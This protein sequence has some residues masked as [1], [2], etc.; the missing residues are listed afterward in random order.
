VL[1]DALRA[2]LEA[3]RFEEPTC[4]VHGDFG[5]RNLII[6]PSL[7]RIAGVIDWEAA[8]T[9]SPL[10]D[11]GSLFRHAKR[12][13]AAFRATFERAHGGLPDDWYRRARVLDAARMVATLAE[14]RP[15]RVSPAEIRA[16]IEEIV[17]STAR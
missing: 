11:I 8:A 5:R 14:D 17:A 2:R 15:A 3:C 13:D 6:P 7:D 16:L 4:L 1:A 9:G 12:H 10:S